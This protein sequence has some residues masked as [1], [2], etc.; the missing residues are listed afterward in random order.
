MKNYPTFVLEVLREI[1]RDRGWVEVYQFHKRYRLSPLQMV[2]CVDFL[3]AN[4]IAAAEHD[5]A[6]LRIR[7]LPQG[8]AWID[9]HAPDLFMR[10]R[11]DE[12][13]RYV[14]K[15]RSR[16]DDADMYVPRM[17][18]LELDFLTKLGETAD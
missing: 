1:Y 15:R 11:A 14:P 17:S 7:L 16:A 3:Q 10:P 2:E 18:N 13:W 6:G 12:E 5:E 8:A 9:A 4:E